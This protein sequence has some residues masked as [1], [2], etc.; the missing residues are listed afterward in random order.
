MEEVKIS[1]EDKLKFLSM[2]LD[3]KVQRSKELI[4]EWYYQYGG[5]VYVSF[6]GG[7]DSTV[8][9]HL[10]RSLKACK[11][12]PAVF[13]DT[14]LEYPDI[15]KFAMSQE[16]ITVLKPKLTFKQVIEKYGYPV[17]S[18]EQAEYIRQYRTAKS[19]KTKLQRWT[20]EGGAGKISEK[21]K[22]LVN[23]P[24]K[25]SEQCCDIMKKGPSKKYEKETGRKPLLGIM[26]TESTL[27]LQK[28]YKGNCNAFSAKR[29]QSMPIAFWNE[30]D[31]WEYIRKY[32]VPYCSI[33]DKGFERTGC[34]FCLFGAHLKNDKR[35]ELM[36][37]NFPQ[38][39]SY[40]MEKLGLREVLNF[41][42]NGEKKN[43]SKDN[44]PDK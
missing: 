33:Y 28:Y 44:L 21:W 38:L 19:E 11:D 42:K 31:I 22:F 23:A 7:K 40:C 26:A 9:L 12:V 39:H 3:E 1:R 43:G 2:S 37:E 6:S 8:L 27:R 35:F 41:I 15:R 10:V 18:K 20:G 17:I 24:F 29:P 14:G 32:N 4:L 34:M 5:N 30:G 13:C 16:N 36:E 25:I